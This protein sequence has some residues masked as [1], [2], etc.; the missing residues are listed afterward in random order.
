MHQSPQELQS[1]RACSRL[2]ALITAPP[3][4]VPLAAHS[5][6][7]AHHCANRRPPSA[8]T[9]GD[10]CAIETHNLVHPHDLKLSHTLLFSSSLLGFSFGP[11]PH[12]PDYLNALVDLDGQELVISGHSPSALARLPRDFDASILRPSFV[13]IVL[14]P[15]LSAQRTMVRRLYISPFLEYLSWEDLPESP[16]EDEQCSARATDGRSNLN[17]VD[18][19]SSTREHKSSAVS[20][21]MKVTRGALLMPKRS[22]ARTRRHAREYDP[23]E[24]M[25]KTNWSPTEFII[26]SEAIQGVLDELGDDVEFRQVVINGAVTAQMAREPL[27]LRSK[28]GLIHEAMFS[29]GLDV[30]NLRAEYHCAY[31]NYSIITPHALWGTMVLGE[32]YKKELRSGDPKIVLPLPGLKEK[33]FLHDKTVLDEAAGAPP[34]PV[35]MVSDRNAL[36]LTMKLWSALEALHQAFT[37]APADIRYPRKANELLSYVQGRGTMPAGV[38]HNSLG[39]EEPLK[40]RVYTEVP[41]FPTLPD[42]EK[43]VRSLVYGISKVCSNSNCC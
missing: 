35:T 31:D 36:L 15:L 43:R 5:S 14:Q 4:Y 6:F 25:L 3:L 8:P 34:V 37:R 40:F 12:D 18:N 33:T 10:Q 20:A 13:A 2:V 26:A 27:N 41:E 19:N 30:N 23:A 17:K 7:S 39:Q 1:S 16:G 42:V 38:H 21:P 29:V 9:G 32:R 28:N 11:L 22:H 24:M